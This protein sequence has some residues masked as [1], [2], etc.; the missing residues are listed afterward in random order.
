MCRRLLKERAAGATALHAFL[1]TET[2]ARPPVLGDDPDRIDSGR[3][4]ACD[5]VERRRLPAAGEMGDLL[6]QKAGA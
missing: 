1:E 6:A 4:E 5:L 2:A 3:P